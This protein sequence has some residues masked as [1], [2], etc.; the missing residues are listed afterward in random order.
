LTAPAPRQWLLFVF[1][2]T[3][4]F[5]VWLAAA[6]PITADEAYFLLWGRAPALGYYDHPPM[7]Y[8]MTLMKPANGLPGGSACSRG[9]DGSRRAARLVRSQRGHC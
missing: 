3:L 6:A 1:A 8:G 4:L 2:A 5:R 9:A 7:P